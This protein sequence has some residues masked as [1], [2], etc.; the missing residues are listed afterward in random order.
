M[1]VLMRNADV[2]MPRDF[3]EEASQAIGRLRQACSAL[4]AAVT[5]SGGSPIRS[6]ADLQRALDI[7]ATLA[8]QF[9]RLAIAPSP[10]EEAHAVPGTK[11][12]GR[13][14]DAANAIGVSASI[15]DE[16][17]EALDAFDAMV[18]ANAGNRKTF[19]SMVAALSD[20]GSSNI[21][22]QYR[23]DAFHANSHI[24]GAQVDTLLRCSMAYPTDSPKVVDFGSI[25]GMQGI[26]RLRSNVNFRVSTVR[27]FRKDKSLQELE[28]IDAAG[29]GRSEPALL[30]QFCSQPVPQLIHRRREDTGA[31]DSYL[32]PSDVG[33]RGASTVYMADIARGYPWN[34]DD[35]HDHEFRSTASIRHPTRMFI[36]DMLVH[37][38]LFNTVTPQAAIYGDMSEADKADPAHWDKEYQLPMKARVARL[39]T[40]AAAVATADVPDYPEMLRYVCDSV[41]WDPDQFVVYR[42]Q[43]EYPVMS[44]TVSMWLTEQG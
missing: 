2:A 40:G 25:R 37:R 41:G 31:L 23:R 13:V 29:A 33:N 44:S 34:D 16:V 4:I 6:G 9:Y 42:Y 30:S 3:K 43:C 35:Q 11:A 19:R 18:R 10:L 15:T 17:A 39:G 28:P 14:L 21:N 7:R 24:W 20:Q 12:I 26:R 1:T 27:L 22:L 38:D 8:W 32:A 5:R 36:L